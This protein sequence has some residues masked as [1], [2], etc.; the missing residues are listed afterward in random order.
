MG[1]ARP[2]SSPFLKDTIEIDCKLYSQTAKKPSECRGLDC[3]ML[4]TERAK[5][6]G[7][8]PLASFA[9]Y[10]RFL[11]S[12]LQAPCSELSFLL[13]F[14]CENVFVKMGISKRVNL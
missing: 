2:E 1:T 5:R 11:L 12:Y 10:T 6:D 4:I 9:I 8:K 13:F 3:I 14:L 7:I